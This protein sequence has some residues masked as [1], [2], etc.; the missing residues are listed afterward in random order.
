MFASSAD[1]ALCR[2]S[3]MPFLSLHLLCCLKSTTPPDAELSDQ[4]AVGRPKT[5]GKERKRRNSNTLLNSFESIGSIQSLRSEEEL[6]SS[7]R[8]FVE[9]D[10]AAKA[11]KEELEEET[12]IPEEMLWRKKPPEHRKLIVR[13]LRSCSVLSHYPREVLEELTDAFAIEEPDMQ[14]RPYGVAEDAV[15]AG[16]VCDKVFVIVEGAYASYY[17][18]IGEEVR[19]RRRVRGRRVCPPPLASHDHRA[20][21][22]TAARSA[23]HLPDPP[24]SPC[25]FSPLFARR[26][27]TSTP[28]ETSLMRPRSSSTMCRCASRFAARPTWRSGTRSTARPTIRSSD[29]CN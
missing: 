5:H 15:K 19:H 6:L 23:A 26:N 18:K 16:D 29:G 28:S 27:S 25:H 1:K 14:G 12:D 22:P 8:R 20:P 10:T 24:A 7:D 3:W 13:A 9:G 2:R 21:Q 17:D 4:Q 11:A